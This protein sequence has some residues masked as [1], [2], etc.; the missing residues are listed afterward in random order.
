MYGELVESN[1]ILDNP[2]QLK[3][4]YEET[5]YLFFRD[6]LDHAEVKQVFEDMAAVLK[7]QG[8]IE[9]Q[10]ENLW[11]GKPL[12]TFNNA[13]LY[14]LSSCNDLCEGSLQP[15]AEKVFG[16]PVF[17]FRVPTRRYFIPADQKRVTAPHQDGFWLR[18]ND[19][20]RTFWMPLMQI[21]PEI[22]G[23][24]VASGSHKQGLRVH[25]V[26]EDRFSHVAGG[27]KQQD[28]PLAT[29]EPPWLTTTFYPGDVLAM[30]RFIVHWALPNLSK[31]VRL[32]LDNRVQPA[33][34]ERGFEML[35][36]LPEQAAIRK[37]QPVASHSHL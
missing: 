37:G 1:T 10:S 6:V 31:E 2:P 4:R 23:L 13:P 16:E 7:A 27:P 9:H 22:G 35:Y 36:T 30:H 11:S 29:V 33:T 19:V 18:F 34:T 26:R 14:S 32:S 28:I 25:K 8:I 20:Y 5:G 24:V 21:G 12:D 3:Q 17:I 15:V